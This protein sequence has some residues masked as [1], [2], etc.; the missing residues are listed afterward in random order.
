MAGE[1]LADLGL[2]E[3]GGPAWLRDNPFLV[4]ASRMEIRRFSLSWRLLVALCVMGG[5]L[6]TGLWVERLHS[7]I[8]SRMLFFFLGARLP[9]ALVI[10]LS[11]AHTLLIANARNALTVSLGDEARR[12]T[13]P[14][15][16]L[17]PLR[18]AEML[19]AMG[20]GPARTAL[21]I[22]L[23]GLPIY[24]LLAEF[25]GL[26]AGEIGLLYVLFALIAYA[27]P[28]Y[29]LPAL[30]GLAATPETAQ[31]KMLS[32]RQRKPTPR[33]AI[34]AT[35]ISFLLGGLFVGQ[36][37]GLFG[38]GWLSHLLLALH[39]TLGRAGPFFL[40]FGWPYYLVQI[41]GG[42]LD[43]FHLPLSPLLPVL[44]LAALN[45]VAGALDSASAL[46]AGDAKEMRALPI[47][48]RSRTVARWVARMAGL[49]ALGVVWKAWVESGD[50]ATLA[51]GIPGLNGWDAAGLALLLGGCS[52]PNVCH[53]ALG[54]S[55]ESKLRRPVF[56]TLRRAVKRAMRPLG[57]AVVT[58]LLACALGGLS[59]LAPAVYQIVGK[60]V[61]AAL[62]TVIWAVGLRRILPGPLSTLLIS[63]VLL[64]GLP[65]VALSLPFSILWNLTALSPA[66]AWLRLFPEGAGLLQR[67]PLWQIGAL[68]SFPV[69]IGGASVT[70]LLM[71]VVGG[72]K[73]A[74]KT[75][76][77]APKEPNPP[78]PFPVK[79]GGAGKTL[80]PFPNREGSPLAAGLGSSGLGSS[81]VGFRPLSIR[82]QTQTASLLAWI[83]ARTDNPLFT[84]EMRTRT[85]SGRWAD[86][87]YIIPGA[88]LAAIM[89]ALAYPDIV[90]GA[91]LMLS[92]FHFFGLGGFGNMSMVSLWVWTN[93]A[94]LLLAG[95]CYAVG[96]RGQTVGE[97]LIARDRQRGIWGFILLTPLTSRQIFWGKL[98]GQTSGYATLWAALGGCS[99]LLYALGAPA[100]GPGR[101]FIAWV[102][103][104]TFVAALFLL[105][106]G[107]G[108]AL[109]TFPIFTKALRGA[110][111]L[112]FVGLV[113]GGIALILYLLPLDP[114]NSWQNVS[115]RLL[116]GSGYALGLAVP[117]FA[118]AE[119]RL[120]RVRERDIPFGEGVE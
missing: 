47:Y 13:L 12:G 93:L 48:S 10:F 110:S 114:L 80:L 88:L 73:M 56:L 38:G 25:G 6:L 7:F 24:V 43:F 53:R 35:V 81:P 106:V 11:F 5:L 41:L 54:A 42:P 120:R 96:F 77:S 103:G 109:A 8:F 31:G 75:A 14:D 9:T 46:S 99:L 79:E 36:I 104:Q 94:S 107:L 33:S 69:C 67:F 51:G 91:T 21:L 87:R 26:S 39:L 90:G 76:P 108:V 29:A 82:N 61:L 30:S 68:P 32:T 83:T 1:I 89:L 52:L 92:P 112:L 45:W 28:S 98:F 59:P 57:V 71:I 20:V 58:F 34:S 97:N 65:I 37:L 22:A 84:Y 23:A 18:R 100:V 115:L 102:V 86:W 40:V 55:Q 85:R 118:F 117:L 2:R 72:W 74:L 113:G 49:L 66:S 78:A 60:I 101:A 70:G 4:K 50:T 119:W 19:L 16:L 15:L 95:Q 111:T 27:P 116:L 63:R 64:Y 3:P 17:T 62:G 105:G 44:P